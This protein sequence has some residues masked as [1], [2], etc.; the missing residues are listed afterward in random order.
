MPVFASI[1]NQ[2]EQSTKASV[3]FISLILHFDFSNCAGNH[4]HKVLSY[5]EI[6]VFFNDQV[7]LKIGLF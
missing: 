5:C 4:D 7:T 3:L 2:M 1:T 6:H